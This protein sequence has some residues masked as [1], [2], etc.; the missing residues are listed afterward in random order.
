MVLD[1]SFFGHGPGRLRSVG[2]FSVPLGSYVN[3]I[4][5]ISTSNITLS[6]AWALF[7]EDPTDQDNTRFSHKLRSIL[8]ALTIE[9]QC[10]NL[11]SSNTHSRFE[12]VVFYA[13]GGFVPNATPLAVSSF[14]CG[15]RRNVQ[16]KFEG[17]VS[18]KSP[19]KIR[20]EEVSGRNEREQ[21]CTTWFALRL[22]GFFCAF[23]GKL[24]FTKKLKTRFFS[25][26]SIFPLIK[27]DFSAI[28]R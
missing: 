9:S 20:D 22:T 12:S 10:K 4:K 7:F 26:N 8:L 16:H 15:S 18:L 13:G 28:L 24:D 14:L 3:S 6:E 11:F 25:W 27:L 1:R 2:Y 21:Y 17:P 23:W 19:S 5:P